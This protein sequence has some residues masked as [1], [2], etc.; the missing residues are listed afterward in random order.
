MS[1]EITRA[2]FDEMKK[3]IKEIEKEVKG[4]GIFFAKLE[5]A[6]TSLE[7]YLRTNFTHQRS[8]C[9]IVHNQ[10]D[11]KFQ[12]VNERITKLEG[13]KE[14]LEQAVKKIELNWAKVIG[15]VLAVGVVYTLLTFILNWLF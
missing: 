15:I 14:E 3:N 13:D 6:L 12:G 5:S 8:T 11:E 4:Q 7:N 1:N 2:E 10:V 9:T